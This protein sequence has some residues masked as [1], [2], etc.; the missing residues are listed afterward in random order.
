MKKDLESRLS[1]LQLQPL[2]PEWREAMLSRLESSPP[3]P[4]RAPPR[5]LAVGWGLAW[6]AVLIL[7][8]TTPAASDSAAP[9]PSLNADAMIQRAELMQSL[10]ALN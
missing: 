5:W 10:L 8:F 6:A 9:A 3:L 1:S 4:R 7:H 2:P